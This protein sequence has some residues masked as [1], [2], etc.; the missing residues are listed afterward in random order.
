MVILA[1]DTST[2]VNAVCVVRDGRI[3]AETLVQSG[4]KHSERLLET[5]EWVLAEADLRP[6]DVDTLAVS[7]GPGSFTGLRVGVAAWKGLALGLGLPL[8]GVPTLDAMTRLGAFANGLVCPVLDARMHEVF[9]AVYSF[10]N[11]VRNKLTPDRVCPMERFLDDVPGPAV[12]LGDGASLYAEVIRQRLPEAVFAN[13]LCSLPR[14]SAVALEAIDLLRNG[15][16]AD[17][18]TVSPVYLRKSQAEEAQ[19]RAALS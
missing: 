9:G 18:R 2:S 7:I 12:F 6:T 16:S 17:A 11:G 10:Q 14:A 19:K 15:A 4:R 1:A 3:L 5:V 8:V 13:A